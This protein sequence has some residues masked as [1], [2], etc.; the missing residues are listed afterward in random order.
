MLVAAVA[1]ALVSLASDVTTIS[2]V[3]GEANLLLTVRFTFSKVV[4]AGAVWAGL[5]ILSGWLVRRPSQAAAAGVTSG[6][7]ALLVHYGVGQLFGIFDSE[8]WTSN[9]SWFTAALVAGGPLGL[10][11][12]AARRPDLW[13]LLGRLT[14]PVGVALEP[15]VLGMFTT[16]AILPW[17][18]RVSSVVGGLLLSAAGTAGVAA[19][20]SVRLQKGLARQQ[21]R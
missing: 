19:T 2:Q 3:S 16:P 1:L 11:G 20:I 12:A 17:P 13:G 8:V 4:N 5:P 6:V 15:F 9:L 10:V 18:D 14:A 21:R 7:T